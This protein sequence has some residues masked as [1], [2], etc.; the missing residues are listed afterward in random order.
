MKRKALSLAIL[1]CITLSTFL[2]LE[3]TVKA[4]ELKQ[5]S[6]CFIEEKFN[7]DNADYNKF[8]ISDGWANGG[9]F[10]CIWRKENVTFNNGIMSLKIDKDAKGDVRPYSGGEYA[11]NNTYGYGYYSVKMKPIKNDG[12]VSS[13]FTYAEA[14]SGGAHEIDIEFNGKDSNKVEFNYFVDGI[15]AG[16][17]IY[18]LGFDASQSFHEYGFLWLPDS[19]TW[20]VDGKKAVTTDGSRTYGKLPSLPGH[21]I[22]NAW[23]GNAPGWLN[24]YDGKTP[25]IAEYDW[26]SFK[27]INNTSLELNGREN[28]L[29]LPLIYNK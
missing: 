29:D 14:P 16:G 7:F 10:N 18:D 9:V 22:M 4:Q 19:I 26:A 6:N 8:Y 12:V 5:S 3:K 27:E 2:P 25:L 11:T 15:T 20:F 13:F 24:P 21:I 28:I 23:C 17:F 1:T